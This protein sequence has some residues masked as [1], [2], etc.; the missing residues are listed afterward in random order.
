MIVVNFGDVLEYC[1]KGMIKSTI[2]RV[3]PPT[4]DKANQSR[5]S[6]AYFCDPDSNAPLVAI[7]SKLIENRVYIKDEHATHVFNYSPDI[8]GRVITA[9]EHL[10]MKLRG[11]YY[12]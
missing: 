8:D 5:F 7:P 2:H 10:L 11:A 1:S 9:G 3:A 4:S 6:I 12:N